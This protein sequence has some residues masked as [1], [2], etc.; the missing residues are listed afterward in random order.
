MSAVSATPT[1]WALRCAVDGRV[2]LTSAGY[3]AQMLAA[4]DVW[5]CPLCGAAATFDD[6]NYERR[7][8]SER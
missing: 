5:R 1:P 7:A 8:E 6:D 3:D 4:G 2:Y